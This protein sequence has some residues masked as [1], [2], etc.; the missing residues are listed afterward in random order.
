M[1]VNPEFLPLVT[2]FVL[3]L[4][5]LATQF[6]DRTFDRGSAG[7]AVEGWTDSNC[8]LSRVAVQSCL[9]PGSSVA[10]GRHRSE[11]SP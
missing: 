11:V 3:A 6:R 7:Y 1:T 4:A 8:D 9:E 10:L 5:V 2:L